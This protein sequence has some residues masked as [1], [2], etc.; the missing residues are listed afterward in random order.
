M[1]SHDDLQAMQEGEE[2]EE[3]DPYD[4]EARGVDE[5]EEVQG[6]GDY[7]GDADADLSPHE[8]L[9]NQRESEFLGQLIEPLQVLPEEYAQ[10]AT[11]D[12]GDR[13]HQTVSIHDVLCLFMIHLWY[14]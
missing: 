13:L 8:A 11:N 10:Y 14:A 6:G 7:T 2:Y 4:T 1:G 3:Q 9:Q 12:L 5:V